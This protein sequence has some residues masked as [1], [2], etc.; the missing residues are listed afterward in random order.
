M[1]A[2][3][4]ICKDQRQSPLVNGQIIQH[5]LIVQASVKVELPRDC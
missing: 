4:E 5:R 1:R 3:I 2:R